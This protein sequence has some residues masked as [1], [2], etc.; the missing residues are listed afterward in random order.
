VGGA[1]VKAASFAA[2][3]DAVA[4]CYRSSARSTRR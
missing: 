4:D 1:S 3:V 2:V